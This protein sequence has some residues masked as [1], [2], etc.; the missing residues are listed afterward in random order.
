[1]PRISIVDFVFVLFLFVS[2]NAL[3]TNGYKWSRQ[4]DCLTQTIVTL[5]TKHPITY[6]RHISSVTEIVHSYYR[7]IIYN[8]ETEIYILLDC[9]ADRTIE[10][11]TPFLDLIFFFLFS[12]VFHRTDKFILDDFSLRMRNVLLAASLHMNFVSQLF[13]S[14]HFQSI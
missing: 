2:K 9:I 3:P 14:L 8:T 1:M 11:F 12:C 4:V 7:R 13:P 6:G 10:F 5:N